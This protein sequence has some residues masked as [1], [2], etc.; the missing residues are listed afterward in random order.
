M[1]R[2]AC[3]DPEGIV[4]NAERGDSGFEVVSLVVFASGIAADA[5]SLP[6]FIAALDLDHGRGET[7][8]K[9]R[10]DTK[11]GDDGLHLT[12]ELMFDVIMCRYI[13]SGYVGC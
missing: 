13:G 4:F 9:E 5:V 12:T 3:G 6:V 7:V 2:T 10:C 1:N 8:V 11:E